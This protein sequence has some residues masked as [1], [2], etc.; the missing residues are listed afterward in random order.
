MS[1]TLLMCTFDIAKSL[2]NPAFSA[3]YRARRRPLARCIA[4]HLPLYILLNITMAAR[5]GAEGRMTQSRVVRYV[6]GDWN[7]AAGQVRL[8]IEADSAD[9]PQDFLIGPADVQPLVVLLLMLSSKVGP[10]RRRDPS[11]DMRPVVPLHLDTVG[12]GETE[13]GEI[14]LQLDIGEVELAFV[15]SHGMSRDLG[16]ALMTFSA[17]SAHRSAN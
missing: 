9:E 3:G 10:R 12:L 16:Q 4:P 6:S 14:V 17:P 2:N 13:A 5:T 11:A 1:A 7:S 8:R 15:L